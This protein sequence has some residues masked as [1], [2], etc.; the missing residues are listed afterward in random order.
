MKDV[1][2]LDVR[3]KTLPTTNDVTTFT[4]GNG[5]INKHMNQS[6]YSDQGSHN[7]CLLYVVLY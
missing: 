2:P 5:V 3:A 6:Q 7:T 4:A 1:W